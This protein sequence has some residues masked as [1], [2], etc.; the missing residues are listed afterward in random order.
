[1]GFALEQL[2]RNFEDF[3]NRVVECA[4]AQ[5]SPKPDLTGRLPKSA[6]AT[7][8]DLMCQTVPA[9]ISTKAVMKPSR[10]DGG[11]VCMALKSPANGR[12]RSI[13]S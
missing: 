3:R 1:M 5:R 7:R 11:L 4:H 12:D 6:C 13:A 10:P 9:S 8:R 2:R